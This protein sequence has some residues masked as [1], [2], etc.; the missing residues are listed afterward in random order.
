MEVR[1]TVTS[2]GKVQMD[3]SVLLARSYDHRDGV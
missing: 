2:A 1:E 3:V